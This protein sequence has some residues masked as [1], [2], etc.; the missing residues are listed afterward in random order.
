[1]RL[2]CGMHAY[3]HTYIVVHYTDTIVCIWVL[4]RFH[5]HQRQH[6]YYSRYSLRVFP[7]L[8]SPCCHSS[9][10]FKWVQNEGLRWKSHLCRVGW[11]F[12]YEKMTFAEKR[13]ESCAYLF[14]FGNTL[15]PIHTRR[16][17]SILQH[18]LYIL[19]LSS[20]PVIQSSWYRF[21]TP[22]NARQ[23]WM[24]QSHSILWQKTRFFL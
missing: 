12:G 6:I 10:P 2:F 9:K 20:S 5:P 16:F 4:T 11:K 7:W 3:I 24:R 8:K 23:V 13:L 1:M 17:P 22:Q 18:W 19:G 21:E 15:E 14:E